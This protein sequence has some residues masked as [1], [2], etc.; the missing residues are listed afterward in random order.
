MALTARQASFVE[1]YVV[2]LNATQ[3]A[4]KAGY[5][6]K[7]AAVTASKL[8]KNAGIEA[9]IAATK[10]KQADRLEVKAERVLLELARIA[11]VDIREAQDDKGNWLPLHEWPE[12]IRRA[13]S[14]IEYER[15]ITGIAEDGTHIEKVLLKKVKFWD[16]PK[17]NE[18]LGKHLALFVDLKHQHDV[19]PTLAE[20]VAAS[21]KKPEGQ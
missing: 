9:A 11:W 2:D 19:G 8:L 15:M 12:N 5:A 21:L 3:A 10:K 17:S 18:L 20:I 4:I 13:V 7:S 14:S 16:K 6:Q 1:H